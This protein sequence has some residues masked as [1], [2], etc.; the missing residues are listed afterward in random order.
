MHIVRYTI[1]AHAC[2]LCVIA[3]RTK[4]L[5]IY[6]IKWVVQWL[7]CGDINSVRVLESMKQ[8]CNMHVSVNKTYHTLIT[9]RILKE[10]II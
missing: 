2:T 1:F 4:V 9:L 8:V 6:G 10:S 3:L 5:V 7:I